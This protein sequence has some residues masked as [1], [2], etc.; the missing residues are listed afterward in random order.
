M[1]CCGRPRSS[2]RS[3]TPNH[4]IKER[5]HMLFYI[6]FDKPIDDYC[7]AT[8]CQFGGSAP[9]A[10]GGGAYRASANGLTFTKDRDS[11]SG[12][13][14]QHCA[15]GT[16]FKA[17]WVELYRD[18]DSDVYMTYE[19]SDAIISA[20]QVSGEHESVEINFSKAKAEYFS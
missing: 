18:E 7:E 17:V 8:S 20:V 6:E 11:I 19:L 13:L 4:F 9:R 14:M 3:A 12:K 5:A 2:G 16:V 10:A 1:I 15:T